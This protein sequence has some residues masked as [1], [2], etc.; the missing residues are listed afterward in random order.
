MKFGD[1]KIDD[2]LGCILAHTVRLSSGVIKKGVVLDQADLD[3]F[4]IAGLKMVTVAQ[5]EASDVH[6]NVAATRIAT[7]VS[8]KNIRAAT[9]NTGRANLFA[10]HDGI[11]QAKPEDIIKLNR[12]DEALTLATLPTNSRVRA[13]QLVGTV[14][15]IPFAVADTSLRKLEEMVETGGLNVEVAV[16][17]SKRVFLILSRLQGELEKAITKRHQAIEKRVASLSGTIT[18]IR[19]CAHS[20]EDMA[21]TMKAAHNSK[22]E[23]ILVFGASAIVD[24]SDV[25][26]AALT[27]IGGKIVKLGMPVDPGNLLLYGS[28]KGIPVIGVPSCAASI[29]ENG[30]DWILE[31]IFAE[32]PINCDVITGM[33]ARGLLT[34]I[35]SRP[36]P[37]E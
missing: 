30:F 8:G 14:K 17:R 15:I 26:P 20:S 11:F 3:Q 23:I 6:E 22:P 9:A 13:G 5:L 16:F 29:K 4:R 21:N 25:I 18:D 28:L 2:A 7:V 32:L 36:M 27:A 19:I 12:V 31:R 24:R 33:A 34:E 1:F 10:V 37:R 35:P